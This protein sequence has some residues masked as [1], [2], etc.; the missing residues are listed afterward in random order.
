VTPRS[1][2]QLSEKREQPLDPPHVCHRLSA[3]LVE[4]AAGPPNASLRR[5]LFG[6]EREELVEPIA[7]VQMNVE[8]ARAKVSAQQCD[9]AGINVLDLAEV[10]LNRSRVLREVA[11]AGKDLRR[12]GCQQTSR[13]A[14]AGVRT[15]DPP[16]HPGIVGVH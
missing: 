16:S 4:H 8:V 5:N 12:L 6:A 14:D 2:P 9:D 3:D 11:D 13:Q 15:V 1:R 7:A 10:D